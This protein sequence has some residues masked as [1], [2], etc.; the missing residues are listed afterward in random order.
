MW[1]NVNLYGDNNCRLYV[2]QLISECGPA[3]V[4]TYANLVGKRVGSL[5]QIRSAVRE[6]DRAGLQ[7]GFNLRW[8][9]DG[10]FIGKLHTAM[11]NLGLSTRLKRSGLAANFRRACEALSCR[12]P[13]ILQIEWLAGS[14]FVVAIGTN[15]NRPQRNSVEVLDPFYGYQ[16]ISSAD[17]QA[18]NYRPRG[19]NRAV[20]NLGNIQTTFIQAF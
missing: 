19:A 1:I 20:V 8:S 9:R 7:R 17:L 6:A 2:Q 5:N 15:G 10:T 3:S 14:H 12:K 18:M 4:A 13:G 16:R 11:S